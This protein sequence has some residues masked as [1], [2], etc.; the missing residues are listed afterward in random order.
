MTHTLR[1]LLGVLTKPDR[2]QD[3]AHEKWARY[4]SNEIEPLVHGWFCIKQHD[5]QSGH[6]QPNL[7][8]A[9]NQEAQY[10]DHTA[11]WR[12][13]SLQAR[14][15]LGTENLVHRLE[16]ILSELISKRYGIVYISSESMVNNLRRILDIGRQISDQAESTAHELR[17]LGNP[18]SNDSIGE[19]DTIVD[20]LVGDIERG[21]GRVSREEGNILYLIEDEAMRLKNELRA[22]C[23]EFRAWGKDFDAKDLPSVKSLPEILLEEGERPIPGQTRKVI[24]LDEVLKRKSRHAVTAP[25]VITP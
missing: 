2:C 6:A 7:Q 9:R 14:N 8:Q 10:F 5:T 20:K 13:P 11:V 12:E 25:C 19:I 16:E 18:P 23:P 15:R 4:L 21:I 22:T 3:A 24:Y 1:D 17:R